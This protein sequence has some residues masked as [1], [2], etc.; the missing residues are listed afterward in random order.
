MK[1]LKQHIRENYKF[2]INRDSAGKLY[3]SELVNDIIIHLNIERLL[4]DEHNSLSEDDLYEIGYKLE[5][6]ID[7][8][9]YS[10]FDPKEVQYRIPLRQG[11]DL[12]PK[13][14][15]RYRLTATIPNDIGA[16]EIFKKGSF[17]IKCLNKDGNADINGVF[18]RISCYGPL[19][20]VRYAELIKSI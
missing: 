10:D 19:G 2:K 20:G 15:R 1:S 16:E 18:L 13:I 7:D 3:N 9:D 6:Y 11:D 5:K 4:D 17:A 14:R 12:P 8:H